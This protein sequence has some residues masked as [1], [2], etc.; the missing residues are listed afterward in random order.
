MSGS[1]PSVYVIDSHYIDR[2][3]PIGND[4]YSNVTAI[5]DAW[6]TAVQRSASLMSSDFLEAHPHTHSCFNVVMIIL[7]GNIQC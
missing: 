6:T 4:V 5:N 2:V 7:H 1:I 3:A